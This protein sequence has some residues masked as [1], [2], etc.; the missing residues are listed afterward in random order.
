MGA[1]TYFRILEITGSPEIVGF[2]GF[3][4][5]IEKIEP[6]NSLFWMVLNFENGRRHLF[7]VPPMYSQCFR[8][9]KPSLKVFQIMPENLTKII[10]SALGQSNVLKF[11]GF[12]NLT[13]NKYLRQFSRF[14]K[15]SNGG[16]NGS[17][18]SIYWRK[19]TKTD[20]FRTSGNFEKSKIGD[21]T[22]LEYC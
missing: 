21:R 13:L 16:F 19:T 2:Y 10:N 11:W 4:Q 20:N 6:S 3:L 8:A 18:L 14:K 12:I 1:I 22:H 17:I 15:H 9:T 5:Y 7:R